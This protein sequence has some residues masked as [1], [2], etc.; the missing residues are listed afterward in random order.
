MQPKNLL[1]FY[2][3]VCPKYEDHGRL[4][5]EMILVVSIIRNELHHPNKYI[6]GAILICRSCLEHCHFYVRKN[7]IFTVYAIY[8]A[9]KNL[10]LDARE[11]SQTFL[12]L[13]SDATCK[14][15]AFVFW[16]SV[17]CRRRWSGY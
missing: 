6:C 2:W 11:P 4:K 12:T 13:K 15:N 9:F 7:T 16:R 5:Q 8:W 14:R 10:I 1:L 17:R 3:E